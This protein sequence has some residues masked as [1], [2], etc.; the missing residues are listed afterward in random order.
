MSKAIIIFFIFFLSL[1]SSFCHA[2]VPLQLADRKIVCVESVTKSGES[3]VG[4]GFFISDDLVA[5]VYHQIRGATSSVFL[6][7]GYKTKALVVDANP[8][9]DIA[10][11]K[12]PS[13]AAGQFDLNS[14]PLSLGQEVF[15]IG[16]PQGLEHTLS[17][18]FISHV[19]RSLNGKKLIQVDLS[20]SKGNS[21]GPLINQNGEVIGIIW[22][23]LKKSANINFAI[24][25][26]QLNDLIKKNGIDLEFMR[27]RKIKA[28]L[29]EIDESQSMEE[30]IEN[31]QILLRF[32]PGHES[33]HYYLANHYFLKKQWNVALEHYSQIETLNSEFRDVFSKQCEIYSKLELQGQVEKFEQAVKVCHKAIKQH[34]TS[35]SNYQY[36]AR[37]YDNNGLSHQATKL[38]QQYKSELNSASAQTKLTPLQDNQLNRSISKVSTVVKLPLPFSEKVENPNNQMLKQPVEQSTGVNIYFYL[39]LMT[40]LVAIAI[41]LFLILKKRNE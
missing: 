41:G 40:V 27:Q 18:G 33:S 4:S 29:V 26:S 8:R 34:S 24:P 14:K 28:L 1:S 5:T 25:I 36:L 2:G 22:G 9:I 3:R 38:R 30:E 23:K 10:I 19:K 6:S 20:I 32:D 39:W 35:E 17:Q 11:L 37:I 12:T 13:S 31:Y 21:G 16:C 15:T 7:N